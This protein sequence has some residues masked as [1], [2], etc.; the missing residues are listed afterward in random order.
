MIFKSCSCIIMINY[1]ATTLKKESELIE[2][3]DRKKRVK[4]NNKTFSVGNFQ[5]NSYHSTAPG[6]IKIFI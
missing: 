1:L 4:S 6:Y 5:H 2:M 3:K